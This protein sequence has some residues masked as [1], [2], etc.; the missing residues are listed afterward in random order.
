MS[1]SQD[2]APVAIDGGKEGLPEVRPPPHPEVSA[3]TDL[4]FAA[5]SLLLSV[6]GSMAT[7]R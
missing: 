7:E 1:R 2:P 3:L 6:L 5:W 4:A